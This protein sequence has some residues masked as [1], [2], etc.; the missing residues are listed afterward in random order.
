MLA[1][2]A[3]SSSNEVEGLGATA[4]E[5]GVDESAVSSPEINELDSIDGVLWILDSSAGF[6]DEELQ[7]IGDFAAPP[8]FVAHLGDPERNGI[9]WVE[10]T[11]GC[12]KDGSA[13]EWSNDGF[14]NVNHPAG[15]KYDPA[16]CPVEQP[17]FR[18]LYTGVQGVRL[19][20]SLNGQFLELRRG[21]VLTATYRPAN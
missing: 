14:R 21:E 12:V 8:T 3:C 20:V 11:F 15:P 4:M 6:S 18:R 17:D 5:N 2:A 16:D 19:E 13:V 9:D 10:I 1:F 7:A